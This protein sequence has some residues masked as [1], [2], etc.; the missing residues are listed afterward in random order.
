MLLC[1]I[2]FKRNAL[3]FVVS[4]ATKCEKSILSYAAAL[5]SETTERYSKTCG[6][7]HITAR[8]VVVMTDSIDLRLR[9]VSDL[10]GYL[11]LSHI[12]MAS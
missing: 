3:K 10:W 6:N 4:G 2:K 5:Y 8:I 11:N 1:H 9:E 12:F 7:I